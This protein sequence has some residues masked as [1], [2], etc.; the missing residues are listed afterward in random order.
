MAAPS[1]ETRQRIA[2]ET[3]LPGPTLEKVLRLLDP[4]Q[5]MAAVLSLRTR[6]ALKGGTALNIFHLALDRLSVDI[7]L[8]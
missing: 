1:A 8:N 6:V 5:A 7:G 4:L 2:S 3:G